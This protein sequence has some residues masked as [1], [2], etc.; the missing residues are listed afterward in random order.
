QLDSSSPLTEDKRWNQAS[1]IQHQYD[2][3][4]FATELGLRHDDNEQF[5]SQTTWSGALTIPLNERNAVVASYSQGFRAPTFN[6]LYY[7]DSGNPDLD[8]EKSET[9]ELKWRSVFGEQ[10][11]LELAL[12]Q[13]D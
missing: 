2:G 10:S 13:S 9:Y 6:D 7:P 11:R 4:L 8:P 1:F 12:Y 3:G 5:G